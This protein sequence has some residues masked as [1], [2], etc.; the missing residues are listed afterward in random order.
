MRK[1]KPVVSHL[2]VVWSHFTHLKRVTA[3]CLRFTNNCLA[4]L[5]QD[6]KSLLASPVLTN[7][8]LHA[9]EKY[10]LSLAPCENFE[11]EIT[12]LHSDKPLLRSSS[13]LP[14]HTFLDKDGILRMGGRQE[15]SKLSFS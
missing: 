10:W 7:V 8:E 11:M 13:L 2:L 5:G 9:S 6:G 14:L 4:R 1:G 3:W 12:S 15:H